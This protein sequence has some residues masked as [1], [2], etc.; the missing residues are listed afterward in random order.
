MIPS[1]LRPRIEAAIGPV[2]ERLT[3]AQAILLLAAVHSGDV[4]DDDDA[5]AALLADYPAAVR[6]AYRHDFP[7]DAAHVGREE[8]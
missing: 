4:S 1:D 7:Q 2:G 5:L 3:D 8:W 6:A